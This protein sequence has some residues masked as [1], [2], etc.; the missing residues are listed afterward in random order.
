MKIRFKKICSGSY[1]FKF[2]DT[3]YE[4]RN[5]HQEDVGFHNE[6]TIFRESIIGSQVV[7]TYA[8]LKECKEFFAYLISAAALEDLISE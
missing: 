6:W 8:T 4:I 5:L 7:E 2:R 3:V 1:E